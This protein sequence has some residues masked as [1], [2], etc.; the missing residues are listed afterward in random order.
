MKRNTETR[1]GGYTTGVGVS[2]GDSGIARG[3]A[4]KQYI[5]DNL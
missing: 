4:G 1:M 5:H 3:G 2:A